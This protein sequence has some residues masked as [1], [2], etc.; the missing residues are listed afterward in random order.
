MLPNPER[1]VVRPMGSDHL[2]FDTL[3]LFLELLVRT[4]AIGLER[5]RVLIMLVSGAEGDI[6]IIVPRRD[7]RPVRE[8]KISEIKT[9][10]FSY[11]NITE[12]YQ[13]EGMARKSVLPMKKHPA[14]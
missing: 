10:S 2:V 1:Y 4:E 3:H 9:P 11:V 6:A 13:S 5:V 14:P 7:N 8:H 12:N